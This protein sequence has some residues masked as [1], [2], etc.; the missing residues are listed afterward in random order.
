MGIGGAIGGLGS[1]AGGIMGSGAQSSAS[2]AQAQA[3]M[4]SAMMQYAMFQQTQQNLKPFIQGGADAFA[5]LR[6][7][8]PGLTQA[9]NPTMEQLS[10]TPGYQFTLDQGLKAA[11]NNAAAKGLSS[12]GPA[13]KAAIDYAGG[14]AS[15]TYQQ[16]FDNYWK[17]NQN[18]YNMLQGQSALGSN[19]ATGQGTIAAQ[20]GNNIGNALQN[21]GTAQAAG[22]IGSTNA[23]TGGINNAI[24]WGN[25]AP[26]GGSSFF[27]NAGSYFNN[28]WNSGGGGGGVPIGGLY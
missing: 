13:M 7:R 15:T 26:Q 8:S 24:A 2:Q 1:L 23:L 22:I 17:N 4:Q 10:Q 18:I 19:A 20:M 5:E 25:Y 14:L 11:Q 9:F 12:S 28:L 21:A 3:A 6:A 27:N 16:N